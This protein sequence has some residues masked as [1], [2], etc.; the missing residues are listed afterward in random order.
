MGK[1]CVPRPDF[2]REK[3]QDDALA[4]CST[5]ADT[6]E[7]EMRYVLDGRAGVIRFNPL[8]SLELSDLQSN[9]EPLPYTDTRETVAKMKRKKYQLQHYGAL[10]VWVPAGT[11]LYPNNHLSRLLK[12]NNR[13]KHL[14]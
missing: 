8:Q 12:N 10:Q 3:P 2:V 4:S 7:V 14:R 1:D 9:L 6:Q 5:D 13:I 11:S